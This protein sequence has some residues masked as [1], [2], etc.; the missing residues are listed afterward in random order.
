[1]KNYDNIIYQISIIKKYR[2]YDIH[3]KKFGNEIDSGLIFQKQS[4]NGIKQLLID[5]SKELN[6]DFIN[7]LNTCDY[8]N[9]MF[10]MYISKK[11]NGKIINSKARYKENIINEEYLIMFKMIKP[12]MLFEILNEI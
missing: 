3:T 10:H 1:M 9:N 11:P 8:E 4:E 5:A 2:E 7:Y 12:M 6:I